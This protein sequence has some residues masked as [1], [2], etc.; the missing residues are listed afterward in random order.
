[1]GC[2]EGGSAGCRLICLFVCFSLSEFCFHLRTSLA[3]FEKGG[4]TW[5]R[6]EV[7]DGVRG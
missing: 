3:Q 6:Q 4:M 7:G 5:M 2:G 1:M